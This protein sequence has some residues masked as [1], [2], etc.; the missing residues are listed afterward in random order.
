MIPS[1]KIFCGWTWLVSAI[2]MHSCKCSCDSKLYLHD[3]PPQI[4]QKVL[5]GCK[6][7]MLGTMALTACQFMEEPGMAV[8]MRE[9]QHPYNNN[10]NFEVRQAW[11]AVQDL[12][13]KSPRGW[14][15]TSKSSTWVSV[16]LLCLKCLWSLFSL[17]WKRLMSDSSGLALQRNVFNQA[18]QCNSNSIIW[19]VHNLHGF[20]VH[21]FEAD[22]ICKWL[23]GLND[24]MFLPFFPKICF[25]WPVTPSC[26]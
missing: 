15:R 26:C 12:K 2:G 3:V 23:Q 1:S 25:S 4:L 7:N 22:Q 9:S 14:S 8:Q 10:T 20:T 24:E 16:G 17:A 11:T 21:V 6:E 13:L 18:L 19:E 5:H